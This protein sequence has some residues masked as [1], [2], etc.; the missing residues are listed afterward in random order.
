MDRSNGCLVALLMDAQAWLEGDRLL[1][2]AND[3]CVSPS[4]ASFYASYF[5][6]FHLTIPWLNLLFLL[7]CTFSPCCSQTCSTLRV[8]DVSGTCLQTITAHSAYIYR[9]V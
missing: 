9:F 5:L 3:W 4:T 8:W 6:V 2:A 7:V 1:S